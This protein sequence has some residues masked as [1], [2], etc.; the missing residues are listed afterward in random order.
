MEGFIES[1]AVVLVIAYIG[2]AVWF[3]CTRE[4]LRSSIGA[5]VCF[6]CG[7]FVI[8][9]ASVA[10]ATFI[11]WAIVIAIVLAMIGVLFG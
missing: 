6:L 9:P 4:T 3:I 7:G 2:F 5:S 1:A 11:V 8:I 10:V